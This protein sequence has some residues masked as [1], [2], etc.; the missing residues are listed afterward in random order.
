MSL[1]TRLRK[2]LKSYRILRNKIDSHRIS[3]RSEDEKREYIASW[4]SRAGMRTFVETG[5]HI[6][7]TAQYMSSRLDRC[8]TIELS[9]SL[10]EA[11][12]HSLA[13]RQNVSLYRGDSADVLP[14]ILA[15]IDGPALFWLDAHY[16][17]GAT[18][19]GKDYTPIETELRTIFA[20]GVKDH[21]VLIDDARD[22]I[23]MN[24]YPTIK[25]L[26][27][28]VRDAGGGRKMIINNDII[29]IYREDI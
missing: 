24:G 6:G 5:T 11:A 15:K 8:H 7:K 21:V 18:A 19:G 1:R 2:I 10:Y 3:H 22:F 14:T 13:D 27:T 29:V 26:K 12:R 9:E 25:R 17:S 16:S 23:G 4:A 20:H 28:L